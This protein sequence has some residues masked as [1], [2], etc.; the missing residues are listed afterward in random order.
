MLSLR[1]VRIN[2]SLV[3]FSLSMIHCASEATMR[4]APG[5]AVSPVSEAAAWMDAVPQPDTAEGDSEADVAA[6][7]AKLQAPRWSYQGDDGPERWG[8]LSP[9]FEKCSKGKYQS[10]ID[11]VT[12]KVEADRF[13]ELIDFGYASMP[14]HLFNNGHTLQV[15]NTTPAAINAAGDTWDLTELYFHSPSEHSINGK[16]A[17]LEVQ[18]AHVNRAGDIAM[19]SVLFKKGRENQALAPMFDSMPAELA[20][21]A[22][23]IPEAAIDLWNLMPREPSFFTYVGSLTTPRCT[24]GVRWFVLQP[25]GEVSEGQLQKLHAVSRSGNNRPVQP[26]GTRNV[27]RPE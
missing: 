1:S 4:G 9:E 7:L 23:V 10:P 26:L 14:L 15:T 8:E 18:L 21:V 24:E 6:H 12:R 16:F 11:I 22:T 17:D 3:M 5:T 27:L 13:L 2:L 25:V 19:V 20:E